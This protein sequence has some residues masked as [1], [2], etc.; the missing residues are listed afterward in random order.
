LG[1]DEK[2]I[3]T[4]HDRSRHDVIGG[5]HGHGA[6]GGLYLQGRPFGLAS[7]GSKAA[8]Y[9]LRPRD[10]TCRYCDLNQSIFVVVKDE[11]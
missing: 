9:R 5:L 7:E 3:G 1:F 11:L 6:A 4:P 8:S 10:C 2:V